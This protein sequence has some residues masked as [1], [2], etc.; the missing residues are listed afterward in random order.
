MFLDSRVGLR[1]DMKF[2]ALKENIIAQCGGLVGALRLSVNCLAAAF[3]KAH[4]SETDALLFYF[5]ADAVSF[6]VRVF[7]SD[8][9]H[10][11]D[12]NFKDFLAKCFTSG[13]TL[14]ST[15][16]SAPDALCLTRLQKAGILVE[17]RGFIKFS[18]I[19]SKRYFMRWLFPNRSS[20][21]PQSLGVLIKSCIE[22]M[23]CHLLAGSVVDGFP[24]EATFQ[25]LFMEGLAKFTPPMCAICPELSK[26]FPGAN[27]TG[28]MISGEMDFYLN[29]SLRW[30]VELLVQGRGIGEHIDRFGVNGKYAM[31]KVMDYVVVD[32]RSSPDGEATRVQ[33]H[34]KRVS[35]FFKDGDFSVCKCIFGLDGE[36]TV[37]RLR[38]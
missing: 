13:L 36:P 18:S 30:G 31:L 32:F 24:K 7:G 1:D 10:P 23:S 21:D 3:S 22:Y 12:G 26:I 27:Q 29:G 38:R 15:S 17:E 35:V 34:P 19:M 37:L 4:P 8:H 6:M 28:G 2:G 5:S 14:A 20:D 11:L 16:L 9:S 25:Q 33:S